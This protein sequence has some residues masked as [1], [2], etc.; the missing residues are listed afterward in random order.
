[1]KQKPNHPADTLLDDIHELPRSGWANA[2]SPASE[3]DAYQ[4]LIKVRLAPLYLELILRQ[5]VTPTT[6]EVPY[7][8]WWLR[9]ACMNHRFTKAGY[10]RSISRI[11]PL[12][13][14]VSGIMIRLGREIED[15]AAPPAPKPPGET[16][17]QANA[18]AGGSAP[19]RPLSPKA[20]EAHA[21]LADTW[22]SHAV[23]Q[24]I[25]DGIPP[26]VIE[27]MLL[28]FWFRCAFIHYGLKEAFFQKLE[29]HWN[30]VMEHVNRYIDDEAAADRRHG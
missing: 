18:V 1:M 9:L 17:E 30:L 21:E 14:A 20:E 29:R 8:L 13:A 7:L 22:I 28:Y 27:S 26:E 4:L 24:S 6:L 11:G 23:L 2:A 10:D 16:I 19:T 15:D 12:M 3:H 25:D 5:G